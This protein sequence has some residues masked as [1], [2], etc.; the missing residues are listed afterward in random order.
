MPKAHLTDLTIRNL[1]APAEGQ[2]DYWCDQ[3]AGFGVRVSQGN[4]RSFV[5]KMNNQRFTLGRWPTVSLQDAR[6][7]AR[8]RL[9][10][11]TL[12]IH[13]PETYSFDEALELYIEEYVKKKLRRSTAYE[14]ERLLRKEVAVYFRGRALQEIRKQDIVRITD[15]LSAT[16]TTAVHVHKAMRAFFHWC[17][18][19]SMLEHSPCENLELPGRIISRSRVLSNEEMARV[20]NAALELKYPF[21]YICLIAIHT[22]MR[23]GEVGG[24][25][26]SYI[27]PETITL[28][29]ELTKNKHEHVLPNVFGEEKLELI[30]KANGK[31]SEYLFPSAAGTPFSAWSD[32]KEA[33]DNICGVEKFV[34][35]DFRRLCLPLMLGTSRARAQWSV[36]A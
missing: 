31:A 33:L 12:G 18:G 34:F 35:H 19:R 5:L 21:G 25:K 16:P 7:E 30:K 24:L 15:R 20:Y 2:V 13:Q 29:P 26:W 8:R 14:K 11:A 28:P 36:A 6:A 32:G 10:E 23:R 22:G 4:S 27:N 9:A 3:L 1:K 17:A